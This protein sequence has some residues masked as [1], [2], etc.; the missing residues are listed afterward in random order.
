LAFKKIG[1]LWLKK[2]RKDRQY[3]TGGFVL[4]GSEVKVSIY[5]NEKK[6]QEKDP[7]WLIYKQTQDRDYRR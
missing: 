5:M 2:D 1:G 3:L 4:E 6:K 7:D